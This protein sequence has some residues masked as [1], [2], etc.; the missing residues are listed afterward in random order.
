MKHLIEPEILNQF[1]A[2]LLNHLQLSSSETN[3]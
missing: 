3:F 2:I 1:Q